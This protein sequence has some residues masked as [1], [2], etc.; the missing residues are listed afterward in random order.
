MVQHVEHWAT[1]TMIC[2]LIFVLVSSL[3]VESN[4]PF[5]VLPPSHHVPFIGS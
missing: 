1:G 4:A 5:L 2:N 3:F